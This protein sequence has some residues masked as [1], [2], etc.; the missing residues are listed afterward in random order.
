M[1]LRPRKQVFVAHCLLSFTAVE[2]IDSE[3]A[4]YGQVLRTTQV[5]D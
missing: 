3:V 2:P 4:E 5:I 1:G